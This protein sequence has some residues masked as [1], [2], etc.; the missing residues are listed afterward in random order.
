MPISIE[1]DEKGNIHFPKQFG[2]QPKE[3]LFV[4]KIDD[5]IV[6]KKAKQEVRNVKE[7]GNEIVEILKNNL[8]NVKWEDIE[9]D[10]EDKEREW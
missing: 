2:I 10:R 5:M 8:K 6:I 9:K 1:S 7:I 3:K 4:D